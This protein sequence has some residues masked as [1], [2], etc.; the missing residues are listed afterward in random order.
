[1]TWKAIGIGLRIFTLFT[2]AAFGLASSAWAQT[3]T[4]TINIPPQ[5]LSSALKAFAEQTNLQILYASDLTGGLTTKGAVGTVTPQEAIRQLLDGTGLQ[6][7]FT[8][9]KT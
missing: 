7:T 3:D 1:M 8:D 5:E 9:A 6:Y 2:L 4:V